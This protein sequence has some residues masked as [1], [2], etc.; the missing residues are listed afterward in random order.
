MTPDNVT[1]K[2]P[3]ILNKFEIKKYVSA[4][5]DLFKYYLNKDCKEQTED[6]LGNPF[7]QILNDAG[8]L[9]NQHKYIACAL[10]HI[11]H[12]E[13]INLPVATTFCKVD[14]TKSVEVSELLK[15]VSVETIGFPIVVIIGAT[16]QDAAA[17]K[18][19][20]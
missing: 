1:I 2:N 19:T 3:P 20:K 15:E 12:S 7:T 9:D 5:Y 8:T 13:N 11:H 18:I 17:K 10:Q 6:S 4:E 16:K 14:T